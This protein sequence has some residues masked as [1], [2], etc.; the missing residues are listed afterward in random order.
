MVECDIKLVLINLLPKRG[1]GKYQNLVLFENRLIGEAI[2]VGAEGSIIR[3]N[4]ALENNTGM[5]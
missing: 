2:V 1:R 5:S 4:E 3:A